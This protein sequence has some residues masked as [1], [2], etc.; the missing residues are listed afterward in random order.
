MT[1]RNLSARIQ[2]WKAK[3]AVFKIQGVVCKR[4]LPSFPS[5]SP[6]FYSLHFS[7]CNSLLPHP[8]ETLATQA[9]RFAVNFCFV[10]FW[11][12]V[13]YATGTW[14]WTLANELI[15]GLVFQAALASLLGF[16]FSLSGSL[17]FST[18]KA[19]CGPVCNR[20]ESIVVKSS[21]E[22]LSFPPVDSRKN[23]GTGKFGWTMD[24]PSLLIFFIGWLWIRDWVRFVLFLGDMEKKFTVYNHHSRCVPESQTRGVVAARNEL[25]WNGFFCPECLLWQRLKHKLGSTF[26]V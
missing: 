12:S 25:I 24:G 11:L 1:A 14:V 15:S 21:R 16:K 26:Q 20:L 7:R 8:T 6:L 17:R 23:C 4:F 13:I 9:N 19:M 3:W 10:L 22:F 5:P 2:A 18:S